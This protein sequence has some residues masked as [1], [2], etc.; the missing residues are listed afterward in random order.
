ME[1]RRTSS[2]CP[3]GTIGHLS[4]TLEDGSVLSRIGEVWHSFELQIGRL[5]ASC[6]AGTDGSPILATTTIRSHPGG[7]WTTRLPLDCPLLLD[8]RLSTLCRVLDTE[9]EDP[10]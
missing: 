7:L 2:D 9:E 1:E 6:T 10:T 4:P 8:E 5:T 3:R